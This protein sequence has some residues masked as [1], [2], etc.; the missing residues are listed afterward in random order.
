MIFSICLCRL[1][2]V[3]ILDHLPGGIRHTC[4]VSSPYPEG[5]F[6]DGYNQK[7]P[8]HSADLLNGQRCQSHAEVP[9]PYWWNPLL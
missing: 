8:A 5:L 1:G 3:P 2:K 6:L 7:A 4:A 9:D